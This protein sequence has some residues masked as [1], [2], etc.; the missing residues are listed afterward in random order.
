MN[1]L[2]FIQR[3]RD[4][5]MLFSVFIPSFKVTNVAIFVDLDFHLLPLLTLQL[6]RMFK[7]SVEEQISKLIL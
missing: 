7:I 1:V 2:K 6:Q 4:W 3:I 5:I